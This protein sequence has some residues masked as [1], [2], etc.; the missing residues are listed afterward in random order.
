MQLFY[1]PD[2][3][4]NL[5][6]IV[7][8]KEESRHIIRVLRKKNFDHLFV[9]DGKGF[10]Y[11]TMIVDD[12][13]K[14]CIVEIQSA[15]NKQDKNYHLHLAIAPTKMNERFEWFIE[16]ATEIGISQIT[17]IICEHSER[18]SFKEERFEKILISA[19]KQSLQMHKPVLNPPITALNFLS[20]NIEGHRFIA[21]CEDDLKNEFSKEIL[22]IFKIE[23]SPKLTLLIGPEGDFSSKEIKTALE[24]HYKAVALGN[25]RLR[26]ETA[27]VFACGV[28]S[29]INLNSF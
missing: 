29:A 21:H 14:K 23:K 15:E 13:E 9:T 12:N 18:V 25:T 27:G 3:N 22:N 7:F 1:N 4:K 24:N 17:P 20:Q 5:N 11:K 26:T 10:L 28:V 2:I 6:Q 8:D 19:M 16:K